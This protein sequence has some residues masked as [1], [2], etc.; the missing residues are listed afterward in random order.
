MVRDGGGLCRIGSRGEQRRLRRVHKGCG[1]RP[2]ASKT[3]REEP[4]EKETR[5]AARATLINVP[6]ETLT[7]YCRDFVHPQP[8]PIATTATV[9]SSTIVHSPS[10]SQS[11]LERGYSCIYNIHA[12]IFSLS[13]PS[14]EL[15]AIRT[16]M[17]QPKE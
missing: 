14:E 17:A 2:R 10:V 6:T 9:S 13:S 16:D 15:T 4:G 7:R 1:E 5:E 12:Y 8:A 3:G 11:P